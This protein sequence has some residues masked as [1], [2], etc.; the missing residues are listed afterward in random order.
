MSQ[1]ECYGED[2]QPFADQPRVSFRVDVERV[3]EYR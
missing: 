2:P 3:T 1:A